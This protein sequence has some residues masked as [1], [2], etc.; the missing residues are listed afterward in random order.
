MTNLPLL[1]ALEERMRF[2]TNSQRVI[3]E[4][5]ANADTPGYKARSVQ[6]PDF[7][8]LLSSVRDNA[9]SSARIQVAKPQVNESG[10][11]ERLSANI[12]GVGPMT[13][14]GPGDKSVFV[15]P[16]GNSVVLEDELIKMSDIQA[17]FAAM[18]N[19]YRKQMNLM[20]TA[21]GRGR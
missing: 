12:M 1:K 13:I 16:N 5:I 15:K 9:Q 10:S 6:S 8:S 11:L 7:S 19:I 21:L 17:D 4:N 20:R 2:L 3:A 18:N 14:K